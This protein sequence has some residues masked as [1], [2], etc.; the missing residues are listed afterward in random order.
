VTP[1][2]TSV[3][4]VSYIKIGTG[5]FGDSYIDNNVFVDALGGNT[6]AGKNVL[7]DLQSPI[8]ETIVGNQEKDSY[9]GFG[10]VNTVVHPREIVNGTAQN[11][12]TINGAPTL[13]N[14]TQNTYI[15]TVHRYLSSGSVSMGV[16]IDY[17]IPGIQPVLGTIPAGRVTFSPVTSSGETTYQFT[18]TAVV[19]SPVGTLL[20]NGVNPNYTIATITLNGSQSTPAQVAALIVAAFPVSSSNSTG[21]SAYLSGASVTF[22]SKTLP[23]HQRIFVNEVYNSFK[24]Q[25]DPAYTFQQKTA[26]RDYAPF[27]SDTILYGYTSDALYGS[28]ATSYFPTIDQQALK[29][30][31]LTM[32]DQYPSLANGLL[33]KYT[34]DDRVPVLTQS[35]P[36]N[37]S[38]P[39]HLVERKQSAA[40]AAFEYKLT[41]FS[42]NSNDGSFHNVTITTGMPIDANNDL[43]YAMSFSGSSYTLIPST[44]VLQNLVQ[45]TIAFSFSSGGSNTNNVFVAKTDAS[46]GGWAIYFTDGGAFQGTLSYV[47]YNTSNPG[48]WTAPVSWQVAGQFIRVALSYDSTNAPLTPILF[49]NGV[50]TPMTMTQTPVGN[51][52]SDAAFSLTVGGL[53]GSRWFT[54]K[55]C[56]LR[57]Y[58]R[59]LLAREMGYDYLAVINRKTPLLDSTGNQEY[60]YIDHINGQVVMKLVYN[61]NG[62][63]AT[64]WQSLS[65]SPTSLAITTSQTYNLSI[66][67]NNVA[68]TEMGLFDSNENM[69]AYAT[70]PPVIYN[71]TNYHIAFNLLV[72]L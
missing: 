4:N 18:V 9:G 7:S 23:V 35:S 66:S 22:V 50:Y 31:P 69:L 27:T 62:P 53:V 54:G 19:N 40:L 11:T 56:E 71:A 38:T 41:D 36:L 64:T 58:N 6:P 8:F 48:A 5:G 72:Q 60:V 46:T 37:L 15:Q 13:P 67:K 10:I 29:L 30:L 59:I 1:N 65:A 33:G 12:I 2:W 39:N 24:N 45:K 43:D 55:V 21:W 57:L 25:F 49:L 63:L 68:V 3:S 70:F 17:N 32:E 14:Y 52:G 42:G 61:S 51:T 16:N 26:S 28:S 44:V 34:L 47:N 20:I